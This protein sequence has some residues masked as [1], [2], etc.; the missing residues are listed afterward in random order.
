MTAKAPMIGTIQRPMK[1]SAL[2]LCDA[3]SLP[4][5]VGATIGGATFAEPTL[6]SG[7]AGGGNEP[8]V[9]VM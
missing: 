6:T 8:D 1:R 2:S 4:A 9:T 7:G 5:K 3:E